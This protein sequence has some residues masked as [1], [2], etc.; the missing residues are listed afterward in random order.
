[1]PKNAFSALDLRLLKTALTIVTAWAD[2]D[3]Q[4]GTEEVAP[5]A[6]KAARTLTP[7]KRSQI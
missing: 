5:K 4:L 3:E 6:D 1:M 2:C 7:L